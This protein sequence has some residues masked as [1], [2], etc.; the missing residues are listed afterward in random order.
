MVAEWRLEPDTNQRLVYR[1]GSL[2][3]VGGVPDVS[4]FAELA[5]T[6]TGDEPG[7]AWTTMFAALILMAAALVVWR[8]TVQQG[9]YRFSERHI[10]G[11]LLGT[12]AA[13][14]AVVAFNNLGGVVQTQKNDLPR[15]VTFLAPVQQAGSALA[16]EVLNMADKFS[17]FGFI[18]YAWPAALALAAWVYGWRTDRGWFRSI[19]WVLGWTLL[20]WAALRY[21]NGAG[22]FLGVMVAFFVLHVV[23]PA[24]RQL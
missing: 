3:P 13:V 2:T 14:L 17:V 22:V 18:G 19:G 23:I 8:W 11:T 24:L 12:L 10:F 21:P 1:N 20:A 7:R 6:F 4:G 15:E 9:V 5:R 16:V